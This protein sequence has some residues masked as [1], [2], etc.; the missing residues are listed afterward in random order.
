M[1][2]LKHIPGT[3]GMVIDKRGNRRAEQRQRAVR[4]ALSKK[5]EATMRLIVFRVSV[6]VPK[7]ELQSLEMDIVACH[8]NGC[9]L[10]LARLAAA[11]DFN[12]WHDVYGIRAHMDRRTGTLTDHFL[13]RFKKRVLEPWER[14]V[15][16]VSRSGGKE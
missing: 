3:A 14:K 5:D 9:R 4:F 1:K 13:P 16:P 7:H 6:R 11:D 2:N 8:L 15:A 12:F 10:D